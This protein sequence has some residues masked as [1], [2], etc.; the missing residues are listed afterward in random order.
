MDGNCNLVKM[1]QQ[2]SLYMINPELME[3]IWGHSIQIK[4]PVVC[5][6]KGH[7]DLSDKPEQS[8]W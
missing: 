5:K 7:K 3:A 4:D 8:S 2:S 6:D 1:K